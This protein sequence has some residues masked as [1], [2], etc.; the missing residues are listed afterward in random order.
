M[1]NYIMSKHALQRAGERLGI[2]DAEKAARHVNSL[3]RVAYKVGETYQEE[4]GEMVMIFD[5]VKARTRILVGK[6]NVVVTLYK[7]DDVMFIPGAFKDDVLAIV[8]RKYNAIKSE[9]VK[10]CRALTI[11]LAE[12]NLEVARL[13]LNK[14][15]A[16]SPKVQEQIQDKIGEYSTKIKRIQSEI[17]S[18]EQLFKESTKGVDLLLA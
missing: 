14:A 13:E 10:Q 7:F 6:H 3:L 18:A 4:T 8:K 16:K 15:K 11:E 17:K 12:C 1:T 9:Y 2:N 5:H